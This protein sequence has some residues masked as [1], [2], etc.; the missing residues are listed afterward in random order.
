[1]ESLVTGIWVIVVVGAIFFFILREIIASGVRS[2]ML[3]YDETKLYRA[4]RERMKMEEAE[5]KARK[6]TEREMKQTT[7][8]ARE[9]E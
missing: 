3:R 1:M 4:E 7:E 5:L 2:G 9:R 8:S 6:K